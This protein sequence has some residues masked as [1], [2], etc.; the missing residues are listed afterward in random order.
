MFQTLEEQN[1][2][3]LDD[4]TDLF[5]LHYI[6]IPRINEALL[7][8]QQAWNSHSL[9]TESNWSPLQLFT[10]Y[11]IDNPLF[12]DI[13]PNTYGIDYSSTASEDEE[14]MIVV[15]RTENPMS[16]EEMAVLVSFV[17]PLSASNSY[18]ADLYM[19]TIL[20]VNELLK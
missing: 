20:I 14:E 11:S 3:N 6:F 18:A 13:D 10:A 19:Q 16:P 12:E 8:F 15:P 9:S 7:E 2:L 17:N 1:V 5:C 4:E